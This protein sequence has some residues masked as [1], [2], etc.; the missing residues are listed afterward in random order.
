MNKPMFDFSPINMVCRH[1]TCVWKNN[2]DG[3]VSLAAPGMKSCA[4]CEANTFAACGEASGIPAPVPQDLVNHPKHYTSHPSGIECIRITEHMNFCLGNAV[5][6]I[7]RADEKGNSLE[8]LQKAA[9]YIAREIDRRERLAR[10]AGV[11]HLKAMQPQPEEVLVHYVLVNG[12]GLH[13]GRH[14]AWTEKGDHAHLFDT[15]PEAFRYLAEQVDKQN[16]A[17]KTVVRV[18]PF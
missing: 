9:W 13:W 10:R 2:G 5:K 11:S 1:C 18:E 3:T 16:P 17:F 12:D 15:K 7:W 14:G 6:Y 8:D 4:K